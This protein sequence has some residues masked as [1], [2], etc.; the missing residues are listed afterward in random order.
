MS[1]RYRYCFYCHGQGFV[2]V[3][4]SQIDCLRCDG[5]GEDASAEA[6]EQNLADEVQEQEKFDLVY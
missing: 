4:K 5:T 1:E 3:E 6:Y 2:I